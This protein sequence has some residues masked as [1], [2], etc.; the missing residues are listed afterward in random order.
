MVAKKKRGV[1]LLVLLLA[2]LAGLSTVSAAC[3]RSC[4]PGIEDIKCYYGCPN[5]KRVRRLNLKKTKEKA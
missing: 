2:A 1:F 4:R 3:S 5:S